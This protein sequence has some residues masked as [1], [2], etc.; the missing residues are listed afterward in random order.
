MMRKILLVFTLL[1]L[2]FVIYANTRHINPSAKIPMVDVKTF[3]IQNADSSELVAI[4]A[5]GLQN[6]AVKVVSINSNYNL[7]T[8]LFHWFF[9]IFRSLNR[10]KTSKR[11]ISLH[12]GNLLLCAT[13]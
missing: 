1:Y 7:N 13:W 2:G 4:I 9:S 10:N 5:V 8:N 3:A 6:Q 12:I 11:P